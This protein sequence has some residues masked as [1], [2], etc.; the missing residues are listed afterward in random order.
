MKCR[1][2]TSLIRCSVP[3]T[4]S[5]TRILACPAII[6]LPWLAPA[7]YSWDPPTNKIVVLAVNSH[8]DDEGIFFGGALPYYSS[9]L[10]LP[11][12]M[13]S[14]TSGDWTP[15][16]LTVREGELRCAAW[17]YGVRYEPLFPRFR[18]VPSQSLG[19]NPYTNRIDA[20]WDYWADG[21][22]QG[23]GSDVEEQYENGT[24]TGTT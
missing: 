14:M 5:L 2:A 8:P 9:A 11:T 21:V 24:S 17:T 20:T 13:L 19:S 12:L 6:L 15:S 4:G 1:N 10:Q 22:L 16:N 7:Q 18:D 23:D 3:A